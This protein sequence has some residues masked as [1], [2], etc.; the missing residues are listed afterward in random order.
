MSDQ[1]AAVNVTVTG[2]VVK[3]GDNSVDFK[4][5][6]IV[7]NGVK[8]N[9]IADLF[10]VKPID[11]SDN[12]NNNYNQSNINESDGGSRKKRRKKNKK[13]KSK[14]KKSRRR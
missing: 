2:S 3:K 14:G 9:S 11:N 6:N 1:T 4:D 8:V 13:S 10:P 5:I 7:S 12:N